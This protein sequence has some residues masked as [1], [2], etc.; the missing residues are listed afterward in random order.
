[1]FLSTQWPQLSEYITQYPRVSAPDVESFLYWSKER[2]SGKPIVSATHVTI[3]GG[4]SAT[5]PSPI[6]VSRQLFATRYEDS[7][8]AVTNIAHAESGLKYFVY[9]NQ[10]EVDLLGGVFGGLVR[11]VIERQLKNRAGDLLQ[12]VR[13]RLE[14]GDPPSSPVRRD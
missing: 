4:S 8:W 10:T 12:G 11:S 3:A 6:I 7:A 13:R 2:L 9:V 1:M 5:L 14:G